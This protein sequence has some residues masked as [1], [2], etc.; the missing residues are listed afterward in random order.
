[1]PFSSVL[2]PSFWFSVRRAVLG[3]IL[4]AIYIRPRSP[5]AFHAALLDLA[6][7]QGR[8]QLLYVVESVLAY[9]GRSSHG[10]NGYLYFRSSYVNFF[11][12]AALVSSN[13]EIPGFRR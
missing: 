5:A 7:A 3:M 10:E 11:S 8:V 13:R 2:R 6:A 1:M 12:P 4:C 9:F